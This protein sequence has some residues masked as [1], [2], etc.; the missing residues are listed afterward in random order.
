MCGQAIIQGVAFR[1]AAPRRLMEP[2]SFA[3]FY[4]VRL[5]CCKT[6]P[7]SSRGTTAATPQALPFV[8]ATNGVPVY[9]CAHVCA[10]VLSYTERNQEQ[11]IYPSKAGAQPHLNNTSTRYTALEQQRYNSS[12]ASSSCLCDCHG[13]FVWVMLSMRPN[14]DKICTMNEKNIH[15]KYVAHAYHRNVCV[16]LSQSATPQFSKS[17]THQRGALDYNTPT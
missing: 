6:S 7:C 4:M 8:T 12:S 16:P 17:T 14:H 13:D 15:W 11:C 5:C 2:Q 9:L 3:L 10:C 1:L